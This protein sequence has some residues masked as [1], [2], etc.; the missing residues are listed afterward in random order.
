[1]LRQRVQELVE[2]LLALEQMN[3]AD[4][5]LMV[6]HSSGSF[7]L[8]MVAAEL[9]RHPNAEEILSRLSLLSLGQN[10]ANLGLYPGA[11]SFRMI[12][13]HLRLNP[14]C[15]GWMSPPST[16]YCVLQELIPIKLVVYLCQEEMA[17]TTRI[18]SC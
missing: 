10:L 13:R 18:C 16:T 1:M 8:A 5:I 7:V 17:L 9:R 11:E 4:E 12:S 3:P 6:G 14:V 2:A 15:P